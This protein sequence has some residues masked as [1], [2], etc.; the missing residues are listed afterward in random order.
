MQLCKIRLPDGTVRVARYEGAQVRPLDLSSLPGKRTLS[1]LLHGDDPAALVRSLPAGDA[2]PI[3]RVQLLAPLDRQE[4]WAAGVTY[5]RS[6][7]AREEESAQT[8]GSRFYDMV[9]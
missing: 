4:V 9:Y 5:Q 6:K 2:L 1:A 8:G 7:V 3:D